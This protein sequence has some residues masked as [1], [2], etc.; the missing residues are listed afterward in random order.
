M[1]S[2][3]RYMPVFQRTTFTVTNF[4]HLAYAPEKCVDRDASPLRVQANPPE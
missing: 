2:V 3:F 1:N 4:N